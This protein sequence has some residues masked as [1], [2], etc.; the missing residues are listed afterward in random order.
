MRL[1]DDGTSVGDSGERSPRVSFL[2]LPRTHTVGQ[3]QTFANGSFGAACGVAEQRARH[4]AVALCRGRLSESLRRRRKVKQACPATPNQSRLFELRGLARLCPKHGCG[5]Q[6]AGSSAI[7]R[8]ARLRTRP[9][10]TVRPSHR[11]S[12][13]LRTVTAPIGNGAEKIPRVSGVSARLPLG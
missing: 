11:P 1:C 12:A 3:F 5:D 10:V 8:N 2:A 6:G 4:A 9:D 13:F 7:F